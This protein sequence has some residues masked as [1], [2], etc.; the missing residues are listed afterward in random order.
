MRHRLALLLQILILSVP[1]T[2]CGQDSIPDVRITLSPRNRTVNQVLDEITLQSGYYFTYNASLIS[3]KAKVNI[4]FNDLSLEDALDRLLQDPSFDYQ[5]IGRNIVIFKKNNQPSFPV[6]E[7]IDRAIIRGSVVDTRSG[8][9]LPYAT[10]ALHGTSLGSITNETGNFAF[11]IPA[12]LANPILVVSYMGYKN[13]LRPISYP[14]EGDITFKLERQTIPLQE[15]IIRYT[16][17]VKILTEA[18]NRIPENYLQEHSGM[19]A[20]YRESVKRNDRCMLFS[21]AMLDV[22]KGPYSL[23]STSDQV[24]IQ[25]GRKIT[26]LSTEDTVLLK[27]RSGITTSLNLD[28]IKNRPDFFLEDFADYYDLEFNDLMTYGEKRVYVINFKQ[29]DYVTELMFQGSIYID[30]ENLAILAVDFEFNPELIRHQPELF[31]VSRSPRL[32]IRPTMARY[33]VDYRSLD[34]LFHVSQVRAELEMKIRRRRRWMGA[35]YRIAIEMAITDVVPGKRTRI[36]PS[37]RV[38]PNT[39][40][41]DQPFEFDPL[42]WGIHNTIEPEATL[43]ESLQKIEHNIQEITQPEE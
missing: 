13:L 31:L 5:V 4:Q 26:D 34:G 17:P 3:G 40:L 27:L 18:I 19:N 30:Q 6:A 39:V 12:E 24:S 8:K 32:R 15:V 2:L 42:Y 35:K 38:K 1:V 7:E 36:N 16:D 20:Y 11:K 28:L 41:P 10:I 9:A 25:K 29:K 14:V 22:A 33:H 23:L 21:E 37:D 43:Q